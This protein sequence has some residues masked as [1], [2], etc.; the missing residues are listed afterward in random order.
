L[1][2]F[3]IRPMGPVGQNLLISICGHNW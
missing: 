1:D 2:D 3:K